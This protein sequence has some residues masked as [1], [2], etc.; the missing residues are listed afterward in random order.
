MLQSSKVSDV[1]PCEVTQEMCTKTLPILE[2]YA[3][4]YLCKCGFSSPIHL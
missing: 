3:T 2:L 4:R 1:Q